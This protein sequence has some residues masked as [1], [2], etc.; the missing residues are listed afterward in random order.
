MGGITGAMTSTP[1]LGV[2]SQEADS[3]VPGLGY[4]GSYAFANVILTIAGG[5]LMSL[6]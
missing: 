1:A 5:I 6:G 3:A 2:V 4:A